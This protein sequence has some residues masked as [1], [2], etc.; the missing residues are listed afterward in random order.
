MEN[1]E[2][3]Y[4]KK[5]VGRPLKFE[6]PEDLENAINIYLETT[7]EDQLTITGLALAIGTNRQVLA[8]YEKRENY[9]NIVKRAKCIIEHSYE[10]ALR[11]RGRS[12]DIFA[13]KN[14]GWKDHENTLYNAEAPPQRVE[15]IVKGA[16]LADPDAASS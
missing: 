6:D 9:S 7:E 1:S 14:F 15:V 13:L 5:R 2:L 12:G 4:T 16:T 8:D 3:T 10:L 11:K